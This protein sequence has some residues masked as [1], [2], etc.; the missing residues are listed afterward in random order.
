MALAPTGCCWHSYMP[1]G[2]TVPGSRRIVI[3]LADSRPGA[4]QLPDDVRK[5][6]DAAGATEAWSPHPD[7]LPGL[8]VVAVP[9]HV[10]AAQLVARLSAL[11]GVRNAEL[12]QTREAL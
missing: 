4:A 1:R 9:E 3:Q 12:D 11:P 5:V 2:A 8:Y 6:L 7:V 10:D